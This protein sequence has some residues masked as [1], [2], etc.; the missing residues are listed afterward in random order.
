LEDKAIVTTKHAHFDESTFPYCPALN[1]SYNVYRFNKIPVFAAEEPLPYSE[2]LDLDHERQR[3]KDYEHDSQECDE[4][5]SIL[6]RLATPPER[7]HDDSADTQSKAQAERV[8]VQQG[9]RRLIIRLP[10]HPTLVV[11]D[12]STAKICNYKR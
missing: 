1:R 6:H 5:S 7:E 2:E 10:Q 11:G 3:V 12:V 4:M 8:P 9:P